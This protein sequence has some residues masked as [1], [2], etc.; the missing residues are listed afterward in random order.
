MA[1]VRKDRYINDALTSQ[2]KSDMFRRLSSLFHVLIGAANDIANT[3]MLDAIADIKLTGYYRQ[4]V[5]KSCKE[6]IRRY[7]VLETANYNDMRGTVSEIDKRR[8]Y[9]D[10]LDSVG[11]RLRPHVF[12]LYMSIKQMLDKKGIAQ[13]SLKA[14]I[15]CADQL[16]SYA[17]YLFD[18]FFRKAPSIPPLDLRQ[19]FILGRIEPCLKSWQM[20][21]NAICTDCAD[22]NIDADNNCKTA[23]SVIERNI[24]SDN[25]VN[26]SGMEALELNPEVQLEVDRKDME[27][28]P[29]HRIELTEMQTKY[30][31]D[32]Y[33]TTTNSEICKTLGIS[34]STLQRIRK[35]MNLRKDA[36]YIAR[37]RMRNIT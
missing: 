32:N 36:E 6:A 37:Q 29:F 34:V 26:D 17:V 20:V 5:K 18:E 35:E 11:E 25:Y 4:A 19:T 9:M 28:K 31:S 27:R 8:L 15:H 13:S 3:A 1:T 24:V 33:A 12:N 14:K 21:R 2:K 23:F 22:L 16:L 30:L 10:F 7:T